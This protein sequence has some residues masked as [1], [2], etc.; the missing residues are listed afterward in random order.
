MKGRGTNLSSSNNCQKRSPS[1][2]AS[3]L[4]NSKPKRNQAQFT[5][6]CL[7]AGH[8]AVT[9]DGPNCLDTCSTKAGGQ[10]TA[11][12]LTLLGSPRFQP[13]E[14]KSLQPSRNSRG[15][16]SQ[17]C[18]QSAVLEHCV[19]RLPTASLCAWLSKPV[20]G[21]RPQTFAVDH[22]RLSKPGAATS[23]WGSEAAQPFVHGG[24]RFFFMITA[25]QLGLIDSGFWISKHFPQPPLS[26]SFPQHP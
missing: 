12:N 6:R 11:L 8:H 24:H 4:L 2:T 10:G 26:L 5:S 16:S 13:Q 21:L 14:A 17:R 22:L 3:L 15:S 7:R 1:M 9:P 25:V 19:H 23:K 18:A 20:P